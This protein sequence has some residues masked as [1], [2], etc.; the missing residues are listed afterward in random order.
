[1]KKKYVPAELE[2][3]MLGTGDVIASSVEIPGGDSGENPGENPGGNTSGGGSGTGGNYNP[4]GWM[5]I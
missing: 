1:M 5:G 4:D 3:F 2:I